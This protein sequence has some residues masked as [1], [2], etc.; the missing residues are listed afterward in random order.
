MFCLF[1]TANVVK[2]SELEVSRKSKRKQQKRQ[3]GIGN[4]LKRVRQKGK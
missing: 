2:E 3:E 4:W 1:L